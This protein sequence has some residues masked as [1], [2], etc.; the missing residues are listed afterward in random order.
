M[1]GTGLASDLNRKCRQCRGQTLILLLTSIITFCEILV[2]QAFVIQ[3]FEV[4]K[5]C[6]ALRNG[7]WGFFYVYTL[8]CTL[9]HPF[10]VMW[11]VYRCGQF[12]FSLSLARLSPK[13]VLYCITPLFLVHPC[14]NAP[15]CAYSLLWWVQPMKFETPQGSPCLLRPYHE[16][17]MYCQCVYA[18]CALI[19]M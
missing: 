17:H 9:P 12:Q 2:P 14:P 7:F 3:E 13:W 18:L 8:T 15:E 10:W 11:H 19:S 1:D 5:S 6:I 16:F 4:L